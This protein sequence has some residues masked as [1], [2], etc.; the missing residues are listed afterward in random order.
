MTEEQKKKCEKIINLY[1]KIDILENQEICLNPPLSMSLHPL[2]T[3]GNSTY[4]LIRISDIDIFKFKAMA[5]S[6]SKIFHKEIFPYHY[7]SNS[8][9]EIREKILK[10]IYEAVCN[11]KEYKS[12]I[13]DI[14]EEFLGINYFDKDRFL[15]K[16]IGWAIA[17]YFDKHFDNDNNKENENN[18]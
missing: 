13:P 15:I 16:G 10:V 6:L 17:N 12:Y 11:H 1:R 3:I 4:L 8:Y 2:T 7:E 18:E 5:I 9:E 14:P